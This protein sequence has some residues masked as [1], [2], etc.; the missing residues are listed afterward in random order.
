MDYLLHHPGSDVNIAE[1]DKECG[2]GVI[3]TADQ[4]KD[5]VSVT[6]TATSTV[7]HKLFFLLCGT[8]LCVIAL[9]P[10]IIINLTLLFC[11]FTQ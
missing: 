7:M 6:F 4:I 3:V 2:V 8:V 10:L 5:V 9:Y 1:F 11:V